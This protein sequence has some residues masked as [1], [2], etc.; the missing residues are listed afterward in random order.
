MDSYVRPGDDRPRDRLN[1]LEPRNPFKD[2]RVLMKALP[3]LAEQFRTQVPDSLL[4]P[5]CDIQARVE[6]VR[7]ACAQCGSETRVI[8]VGDFVECDCATFY[9]NTGISVRVARFEEDF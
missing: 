9:L 7:V 1:R 2:P 4:H 8:A 3:G 6:G 5:A